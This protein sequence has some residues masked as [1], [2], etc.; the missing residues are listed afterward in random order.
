MAKP[1]LCFGHVQAADGAVSG[2]PMT[3]QSGGQVQSGRILVDQW[4]TSLGG[5]LSPAAFKFT[6]THSKPYTYTN[7]DINDAQ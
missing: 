1:E 5:R 7:T 6:P 2:S 3:N 4:P